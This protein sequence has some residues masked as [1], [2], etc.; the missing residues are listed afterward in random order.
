M[1]AIIKRELKNYLKNPVLW[2]GLVF[3]IFQLYQTL[4]PYLEIR[5][6]QSEKDI[7]ALEPENIADADITEG[8]VLS[9]K[10]EQM[11]LA[12]EKIKKDLAEAEG[13]TEQEADQILEDMRHRGLSIDEMEVELAEKYEFYGK[14]GVKYYYDISEYHKAGYEE[15]NAYIASNLEEHS[16][17]YYFSRKFADFCGLFMGFFSSVLLAFLF[18]RDS[19]K[20]TYE[21]LHTKPISSGAYVCGKIGGGFFAMLGVWGIL[22]I[23]FG[24]LCEFC[25]RRAGFPVSMADFIITAS[26]YILPNML[27]IASIYGAAALIFKNPLPA[28]PLLFLYLIYS[29]MGSI[30]PDGEYG[31]F[32]RPL[33]IMVRF[34]GKFFETAPPPLALLNQTFLSAAAVLLIVLGAEIWKRRRFY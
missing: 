15:A 1:K 16:F 33:A 32:G 4:N 26:V 5:Y 3:I 18:I 13:I 31:Y 8:Y 11:A 23:I 10:E 27:M 25:G 24:G 30:G 2:V 7:E 29:N 34:P 14:Y 6:Y 17:S 20:D 9:S 12:C 28:V 19:K 21:L 22:T